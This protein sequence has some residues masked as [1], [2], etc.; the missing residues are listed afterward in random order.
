MTVLFFIEQQSVPIALP[1]LDPQQND[2][3]PPGRAAV[4]GSRRHDAWIGWE[5][6]GPQSH[7]PSSSSSDSSSDSDALSGN[8]SPI[9]WSLPDCASH[10]YLMVTLNS[11]ISYPKSFCERQRAARVR[12]SVGD[13]KC[14]GP[15]LHSLQMPGGADSPGHGPA[16]GSARRPPCTPRGQTA[17]S[18]HL[19]RREPQAVSSDTELPAGCP[20]LGGTWLATPPPTPVHARV[21][22]RQHLSCREGL[23]GRDCLPPAPQCCVLAPS[24]HPLCPQL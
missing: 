12:R 15:R 10:M 3:C 9:C 23:Q 22:T 20:E 1:C 18:P 19:Q 21:G 5:P 8:S 11:A 14:L 6:L 2:C 17:G 4:P 7:Q 24:H 16:L 13:Q